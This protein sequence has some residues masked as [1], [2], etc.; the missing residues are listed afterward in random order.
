MLPS[1]P[2]LLGNRVADLH[3]PTAVACFNICVC[4]ESYIQH[5]RRKFEALDRLGSTYQN[6]RQ[7]QGCHR[8]FFFIVVY[9]SSAPS[10]SGSQFILQK[11]AIFHRSSRSYICIGAR[12]IAPPCKSQDNPSTSKEVRDSGPIQSHI[13]RPGFHRCG[14]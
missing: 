5:L 6:Q 11:Q 1:P 3:T 2:R 8:S 13:R 4:I 7:S 10:R 12:P 9:Y 14:Y